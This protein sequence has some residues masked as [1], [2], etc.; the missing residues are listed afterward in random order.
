MNPK[1]AQRLNPGKTPDR[2]IKIKKKIFGNRQQ[3]SGSSVKGKQT[4][5][6]IRPE[7]SVLVHLNKPNP[8]T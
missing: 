6:Y 1:V 4:L 2:D 7:I 8:P 5:F 3:N